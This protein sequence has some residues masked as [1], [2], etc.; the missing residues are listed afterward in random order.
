MNPITTLQ[1]MDIAE[2]SLATSYLDGVFP[3][4]FETTAAIASALATLVVYH[5]PD[6]YY[7][8]Y[9]ARIRGVTSDRVLEAARRHVDP[10]ALQI[11]SSP[12]QVAV[13]ARQLEPFAHVAAMGLWFAG[14][15]WY[16]S[17]YLPR[18]RKRA[19]GRAAARDSTTANRACAPSAIVT[20]ASTVYTAITTAL[21][22]C[23]R[24]PRTP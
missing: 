18:I 23:T 4:R 7:D 12:P 17:G 13:P 24:N 19:E 9:R 5:L 2:L 3:I 22:R 14:Y 11:V 21:T 16:I 10:S 1:G 8:T 15:L 20:S 6:D